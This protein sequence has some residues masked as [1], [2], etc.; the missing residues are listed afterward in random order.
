[1]SK[2]VVVAPLQPKKIIEMVVK[3][4]A[5]ELFAYG[6]NYKNIVMQQYITMGGVLVRILEEQLWKKHSEGQFHSFVTKHFGLTKTVSTR[7]MSVYR[8]IRDD[9]FESHKLMEFNIQALNK[10]LEV[11][12]PESIDYWWAAYANNDLLVLYD[13]VSAAKELGE[14][15]PPKHVPKKRTQ[16]VTLKVTKDLAPHLKS[17]CQ[18]AKDHCGIK[19]PNDGDVV[20]PA[21]EQYIATLTDKAA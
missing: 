10:V 3:L 20:I 1:M 15:Y 5:D 13:L 7:M 6:V 19:N 12:V 11:A 21:I 9:G 17:L 4:E 18:I 14:V 8:K 16:K 2:K